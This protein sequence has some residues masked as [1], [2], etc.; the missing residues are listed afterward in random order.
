MPTVVC[1]GELLIDFVPTV[2]GV[3]LIEAPA[4][5][6]AAGGGV[7][8]VSVGLARLGVSSGFM[9]QVGDDPF[10]HFL[11]QTLAEAG[12]DTATLCFSAE[13]RTMLAFVA[14]KADGERDFIF[15]RNPSA[16]MLY[17][18]EQVA[19]DYVRDATLLHVSSISTI[20]EPARAATML[21]IETA[22]AA[23]RLVSF[24]PNLRLNLWP[25]ADA[26]R[27]GILRLWPLAHIIKAGDEELHFLTGEADYHKAAERL[28]HP[29]LK[30]LLVTHGREGSTYITPTFSGSVPGF[31]VPSVDTTGAGDGFM[32]A[33]LKGL[34][35]RADAY[36]DPS[37]MAEICR[38]A[39][40]VGAITTL[41]RGGIPAL[42]TVAQVEA[43]LAG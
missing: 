27:A 3:D 16:D 43:F 28:W 24:D 41:E 23:G 30:I 36:A 26:A 2:S 32:A 18:P 38:F 13:A 25:S 17:R 1:H 29:E 33:A 6:K 9:G 37:A 10:G 14:L 42:P 34:L 20:S 15:Y 39:N 8:N 11:A 19:Q 22:R 31:P 7:A 21:A 5:K 4:F 12:V 40:A 35:E